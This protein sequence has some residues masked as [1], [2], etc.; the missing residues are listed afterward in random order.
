MHYGSGPI[1]ASEEPSLDFSRVLVRANN[2]VWIVVLGFTGLPIYAQLS[3]Q[4]VK[5]WKIQPVNA[6]GFPRLVQAVALVSTE[7]DVLGAGAES[8]V[9]NGLVG[10][11]R[12][13]TDGPL[14]PGE[15]YIV[16]YSGVN[17]ESR[18]FTALSVEPLA[19]ETTAAQDTGTIEDFKN[20][21]LSRDKLPLGQ[22][23]SY[24]I[25]DDG[26]LGIDDGLASLRKRIL[27]RITTAVSGF[28]HL[29]NYGTDLETKANLTPDLARRIRERVTSG[30]NKEPD[31]LTSTTRVYAVTGED[32]MVV[33]Q[34][35]ATTKFGQTVSVS[36]QVSV[37]G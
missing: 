20:P 26:D 34:V 30:V 6:T 23:G 13:I 19:I 32:G 24:N 31:V 11:I 5:N 17:V 4:N 16:T 14:S 37:N 25:T 21:Q 33:V 29:P 8:Y 28:Y 18:Y 12:I 9:R 1:G 15:Q 27:R 36:E 3:E 10:A 35:T 7:A 22:L 2:E